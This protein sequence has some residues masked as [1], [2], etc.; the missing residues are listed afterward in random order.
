[1]QGI[2]LLPLA[3]HSRIGSAGHGITFRFGPGFEDGPSLGAVASAY[4]T[5]SNRFF[6]QL[7]LRFVLPIRV[8]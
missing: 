2:T 4:R 8:A 5:H 6:L 1:M 7:Y 3:V